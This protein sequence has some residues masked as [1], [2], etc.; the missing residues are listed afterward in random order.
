MSTLVVLGAGGHGRVVAE[1][2]L[3]TS[4]WRKVV[5]LDDRYPELSRAGGFEVVGTLADVADLAY[6]DREA[7]V[8]VG[9][10]ARRLGLLKGLLSGGWTLPV[11]VHPSAWVSRS[12]VLGAGSVVLAQAAVNGGAQLGLGAIVNTG[13][14]IDHDCQLGD[15]VHVSPGAHIGGEVAIGDLS[16]VGIGASVRHCIQIGSGATIGAGA[17]VVADVK[18]GHTVV[19]VPARQLREI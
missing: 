17:A 11:L 14:T 3:E 6:G 18:D 10:N 9:A 12:A 8:A 13:A 7:L 4:R 2:A 15:G 5:L 19:G 1:A 16:W